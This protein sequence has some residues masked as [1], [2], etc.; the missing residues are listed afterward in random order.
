VGRV[1]QDQQLSV[2][3]PAIRGN[4]D[5]LVVRLK[6]HLVE[7]SRITRLIEKGTL[8]A[9]LLT[10]DAF[11]WS[12]QQPIP[13]PATGWLREVLGEQCYFGPSL[14]NALAE[15]GFDDSSSPTKTCSRRA[16]PRIGKLSAWSPRHRFRRP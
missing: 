7:S 10:R 5:Q 14:V 15:K 2:D 8:H 16:R 3:I 4:L 12:T 11:D 13:M 1:A 6:D 9:Y